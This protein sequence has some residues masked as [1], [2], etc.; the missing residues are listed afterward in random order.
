[1]KLNDGLTLSLSN[2]DEYFNIIIFLKEERSVSLITINVI[3]FY[4]CIFHWEKSVTKYIMYASG[5]I[6]CT[7]NLLQFKILQNLTTLNFVYAT[8]IVRS[9]TSLHH[10]HDI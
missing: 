2:T 1:M 5:L 9:L 8:I 7:Y 10:R 6:D 3:M 4:V